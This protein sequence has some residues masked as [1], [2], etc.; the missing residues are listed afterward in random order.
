MV[1]LGL[2]V[3]LFCLAAL[4]LI[5]LVRMFSRELSFYRSNG[6]DFDLDSGDRVWFAGDTAKVVPFLPLGFHKFFFLLV[7]M[8]PCVFFPISVIV[9]IFA[10]G[11]F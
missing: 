6:W 1:R 2:M 11:I 4:F 9:R 5:I 7:F 3:G 8:V 10:N